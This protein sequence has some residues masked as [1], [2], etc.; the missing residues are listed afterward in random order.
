MLSTREFAEKMSVNYRT[1][2]NWLQSGIVPGAVENKLPN[3][4]TFWD[5]PAT[6]L[7]MEKPKKGP[8]PSKNG[9]K[10]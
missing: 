5:I 6:A 10:K 1:A 3:G 7:A 8:K 2:L 4:I 9:S